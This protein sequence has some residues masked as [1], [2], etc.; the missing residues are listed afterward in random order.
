MFCFHFFAV[1]SIPHLLIFLCLVGF[2]S[3]HCLIVFVYEALS[4]WD[5]D[6]IPNLFKCCAIFMFPLTSVPLPWWFPNYSNGNQQITG[7]DTHLHL[8]SP[9]D[10]GK[11]YE[12]KSKKSLIERISANRKDIWAWRDGWLLG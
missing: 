12:I 3:H 1:C 4:T 2:P 10:E 7:T 8:S 5:H 6:L 11:K 9:K